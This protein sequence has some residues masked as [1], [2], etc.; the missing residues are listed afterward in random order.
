MSYT[1]VQNMQLHK[2]AMVSVVQQYFY[3]RNS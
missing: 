1:L 3:T 2:G